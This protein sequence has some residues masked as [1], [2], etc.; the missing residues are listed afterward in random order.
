M[1]S[2]EAK[3]SKSGKHHKTDEKGDH[4]GSKIT[5]PKWAD[6]PLDPKNDPFYDDFSTPIKF[7][8]P[9]DELKLLEK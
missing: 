5:R 6:Y 9:D 8:A 7:K 2:N 3:K 4:K 1:S